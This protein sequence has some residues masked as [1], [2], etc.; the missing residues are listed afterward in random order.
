MCTFFWACCMHTQNGRPLGGRKVGG[1]LLRGDSAGRRVVVEGADLV[2]VVAPVLHLEPRA[3]TSAGRQLLNGVTNRLSC[4]NESAVPKPT[5]AVRRE[6]LGRC[7]V[8]EF[9]HDAGPILD[10]VSLADVVIAC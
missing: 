4:V 8:V 5:A 1:S 6:E 10:R 2:S 3:R 9:R 7:R